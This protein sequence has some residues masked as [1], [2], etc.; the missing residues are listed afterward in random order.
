MKLRGTYE[1][2]KIFQNSFNKRT[3]AEL[4]FSEKLLTK[5]QIQNYDKALEHLEKILNWQEHGD[6]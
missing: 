3:D 5:T 1:A 4:Y 2:L 6:T